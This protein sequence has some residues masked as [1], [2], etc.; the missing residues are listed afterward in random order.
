[1]ACTKPKE[2]PPKC[3]NCGENHPVN[4]RGCVV[5]KEFEALR[6][7]A[8]NPRKFLLQKVQ[9]VALTR[10]ETISTQPA[11]GEAQ[12]YAVVVKARPPQPQ[13]QPITDTTKKDKVSTY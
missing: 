7:K 12:T 8:T 6:N 3:Y 1:M 5:A 2:T 11:I 9:Q 4:Y 10:N 13:E